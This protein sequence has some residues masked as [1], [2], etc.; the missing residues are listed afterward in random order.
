[1]MFAILLFAVGMALSA[2]F[3]GSETGFYRVTRMRLLIDALGGN[4]VARG[5]LWTTNRPSLFVATA[6]VGNNLANYI[7]SLSVVMGAQRFFVGSNPMAELA[8][9]LILAPVVFIYGELLPKDLFYRAPN[10]L[11]LRSGP[12][13][14]VASLLF[15]PITVL[16]WMFSMILQWLVQHSP[17]EIRLTLARQE[18]AA[19]LDEG[20][21][22]GILH[23]SQQA[24]VQGTFALAGQPIRNF[25]TPT[26]RFSRIT[27]NTSKRDVLRMAK[28][29][30][31]SLIPVEEP[32]GKRKLL[33][34]L[35]LIDLV[36]DDSPELP[37]LRPLVQ[38]KESETYLSALMRLLAAEHGLGHV[39]SEKGKSIGFVSA[40]KLTEALLEGDSTSD[41][42][43]DQESDA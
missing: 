36:L 42:N 18:L 16:L 23:P 1:M 40:Q 15:A 26:G 12:A 19:V 13:L 31:R 39:V 10:R 17:Q 3:S 21:E 8:A 6:L 30:G 29:Q 20:H 9:P 33:G 43:S 11:L 28:R 37:P 4:W 22:V 24:M 32:R 34:Y 38:L 41:N 27:S 35:R 7:V 14:L 5:L 25:A 2:F